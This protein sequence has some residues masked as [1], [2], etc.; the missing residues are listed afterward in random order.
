MF[1]KEITINNAFKEWL[2]EK[3]TW[4]DL[5][6][7]FGT[8]AIATVMLV[9][10]NY[11][12]LAGL[13]LWQSILFIVVAFDI[14]GGCVANFTEST[15]WYYSRNAAKRWVFLAEHIVHITLLYL[16]SGGY[17]LFWSSVFI[18]TIGSGAIVQTIQSRRLQQ[19]IAGSLVTIGC[20]LFYGIYE[21]E[22]PLLQWFPALFMVKIIIG[23]A[24][25]RTGHAEN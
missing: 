22:I 6:V 14:I 1:K 7:T 18:Y 20:M 3:P 12:E 2:G 16:A 25:R 15:D 23:F 13:S 4:G 17:L 5:L 19:L 8:A 21:I 9:L 11:T 24:V 10:G